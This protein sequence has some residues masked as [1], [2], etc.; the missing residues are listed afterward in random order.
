MSNSRELMNKCSLA[1]SGLLEESQ[2]AA[3]VSQVVGAFN[4]MPVVGRNIVSLARS[5]DW[6]GLVGAIGNFVDVNEASSHQTHVS[7][8]ATA[9][10]NLTISTNLAVRIIERDNSLSDEQKDL[11]EDLLEEIGTTKNSQTK[12]RK[13]AEWL[14]VASDSATVLSALAPLIASLVASMA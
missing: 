14:S 13:L 3:L 5:R 7:A 11:L 9:N 8:T 10:T 2:C 1:A 12:A 6:Y 4:S